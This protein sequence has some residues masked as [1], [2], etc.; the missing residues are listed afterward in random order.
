MV[1][2]VRVWLFSSA[3][4]EIGEFIHKFYYDFKLLSFRRN[5]LLR[6]HKFDAAMA[7]LVIA[8]NPISGNPETDL[9]KNLSRS[10]S[11]SSIS[12]VAA[13]NRCVVA[14]D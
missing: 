2:A 12:S 3:V 6:H 10:S 8:A 11:S 14:C 1:S 9:K 5:G 4:D 7:I 13:L